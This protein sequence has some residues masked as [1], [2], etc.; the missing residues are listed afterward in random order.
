MNLIESA[1]EFAREKH[2]PQKRNYTDEPYFV[3]L[4][5]VAGIVERAGLTEA[6]IAAAWLH[7]TVEDT[8]ATLP[9]I[10]AKF[11]SA[12]ALMVLDLTDTPP[13]P[14]LNRASRREIDRRRLA[15]AGP[16]TQGIKC[17]DLISNTST[18]VMHN[19]GFA[20]KYLPEKRATLEILT[21]APAPLL[22][23]AWASLRAA[24]VELAA[25]Q[26]EV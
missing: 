26:Q 14:G 8:D 3:H 16:E 19:R 13:G 7:D 2:A 15:A 22:D 10:C 21:K 6:A 11:G 5:E 23:Q 12:V 17:A 20:T 24:E 18:I 9:E 25:R 1:R 4:E